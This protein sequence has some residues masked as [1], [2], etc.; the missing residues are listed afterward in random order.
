MLGVR[1]NQT[2]NDVVNRIK[3]KELADTDAIFLTGDLSQDQSIESYQKMVDSFHGINKP[4]F[5]IPGNHDCI[6][7]SSN[8]F[9]Q[10]NKFIRTSLFETEHWNFIFLNTKLDGTDAGLLSESELEIL[11]T[12]LQKDKTKLH[13]IIVHHQPEKIGTPMM[14]EKNLISRNYRVERAFIQGVIIRHS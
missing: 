4:I 13:A 10:H 8:I 14:D 3:H 9:S 6:T 1:T 12:S 7:N 5:W 11:N 2:Y